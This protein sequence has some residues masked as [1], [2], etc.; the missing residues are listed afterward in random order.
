MQANFSDFEPGRRVR[1][2]TSMVTFSESDRGFSRSATACG[3]SNPHRRLSSRLCSLNE[4]PKGLRIRDEKSQVTTKKAL[5]SNVCLLTHSNFCPLCS[6]VIKY[7]SRFSI[8]GKNRNWISS[9][10]NSLHVRSNRVLETGV[11]DLSSLNREVR[12]SRRETGLVAF[13]DR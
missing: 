1:T 7:Y 11:G 2:L 13:Q 8:E 10:L 9:G 3:S 4:E 12:F 5:T 6:L